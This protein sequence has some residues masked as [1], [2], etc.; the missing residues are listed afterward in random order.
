MRDD[1][2]LFA[3]PSSEH[4]G[5]ADRLQNK[6]RR[7]S[8]NKNKNKRGEEKEKRTSNLPVPLLESVD[9]IVYASDTLDNL[10]NSAAWI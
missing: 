8:I 2:H 7:G 3:T 6:A 9:G 5:D 10:C 4:Q 1:A